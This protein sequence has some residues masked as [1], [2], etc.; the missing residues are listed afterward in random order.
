MVVSEHDELKT[1]HRLYIP[2]ERIEKRRAGSTET[3]DTLRLTERLR[4]H[5]LKYDFSFTRDPSERG[6]RLAVR[7]EEVAVPSIPKHDARTGGA[8]AGAPGGSRTRAQRS[9]G[10]NSAGTVRPEGKGAPGA[11]HPAKQS[12]SAKACGRP[13]AKSVMDFRAGGAINA[14]ALSRSMEELG[15]PAKKQ[16]PRGTSAPGSAQQQTERGVSGA[17]RKAKERKPT[18]PR[19][20]KEPPRPDPKQIRKQE[21]LRGLDQSETTVIGFDI[22]RSVFE[23]PTR[24]ELRSAEPVSTRIQ[25]GF[26][27]IKGAV[28]WIVVIAATFLLLSFSLSLQASVS[29]VTRRNA[30][31][32]RGITDLQESVSKAQMQVA[33]KDDLDAVKTRAA[34][35][36]LVQPDEEQ[37]QYVDL[38]AP[39]ASQDEQMQTVSSG[40]GALN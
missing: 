20:K 28:S 33:L 10:R 34:V 27:R 39:D 8:S 14:P 11:A 2:D 5:T 7:P 25:G 31:L 17:S 24:E 22:S 1:Y 37:I 23:K 12:I 38:G 4:S 18:P 19:A 13:Q 6:R 16:A 21:A 30:E 3:L 9:A 15:L 40:G 26:K 29:D 32:E 36:G 35:L